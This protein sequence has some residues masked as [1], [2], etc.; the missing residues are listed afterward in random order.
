M[1]LLLT[2]LEIPIEKHYRFIE[3]VP[4]PV[5]MRIANAGS[6]KISKEHFLH[7]FL[8]LMVA[9]V[10]KLN[11]WFESWSVEGRKGNV[12]PTCAIWMGFNHWEIS[13]W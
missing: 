1:L 7:S 5:S 2:L 11:D 6:T 8:K 12:A 13:N 9:L 4:Q 3:L 10:L